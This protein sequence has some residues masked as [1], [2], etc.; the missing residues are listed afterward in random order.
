MMADLLPR[1][2]AHRQQWLHAAAVALLLAAALGQQPW[3]VR[4]AGLAFAAAG[5]Y[6]WWNLLRAVRFRAPQRTAAGA[7]PAATGGGLG[8]Q[9]P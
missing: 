1:R 6:L 5:G 8:R 3:L 7:A 9:A 4:L 2:H